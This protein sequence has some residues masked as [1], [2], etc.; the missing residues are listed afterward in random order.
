MHSSSVLR[1]LAAGAGSIALVAGLAGCTQPVEAAE[2]AGA[3]A[4]VIG[5]H[6]NMPVPTADGAAAA[7]LVAAMDA[8]SYLSVFVADGDPFELD[9]WSLAVSDAND[10]AAEA[11]RAAHRQRINADL[12]GAAAQTPEVDLLGA[13]DEAAR[14]ITSRSGQHTIVVVDSGLSTVAP[15][16]FTQPGMLDADPAEIATSLAAAGELPELAGADVVLQGLGD[17]ADPQPAIGRAQQANLIGIWTAIAEAAG[18]RDV[19]V[20]QA[21]LTGSAAPGLPDV[22]IVPTGSSVRCSAG[23]VT[24]TGGDVA[25]RP[26]SADFADPDAARATLGPIAEQLVDAS[27]TATVTGTTA[28]V[29]DLDGQRS[30]SRERAQAVS[31]L[32]ADLGVPTASM[33]VLG[34]GSE[35][36]GYVVD[37]DAAGNLIPA[38]AAANRTVVIDLAG[39]P[40]GVTCASA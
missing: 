34:L 10:Q 22:S 1:R 37:H 28:R 11:D 6:G 4:L 39:A 32:L 25:F 2:P 18:A 12:A 21:P 29:G 8:Q 36:P 14:S 38:A 23:T 16:D 7:A 3:L 35:F 27:S 33:T 17:T 13:I 9:A 20:E 26:D 31:G 24:L 19:Q 40:A 15:L 5:A 30:L